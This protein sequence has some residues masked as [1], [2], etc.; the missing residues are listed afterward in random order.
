MLTLL[1][2]ALA[3]EAAPC[4][5]PSTTDTLLV[6]LDAAKALI[7]TN[8]KAASD[9]ATRLVAD[10]TC[11]GEAVPTCARWLRRRR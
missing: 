6:D 8:D 1:S 5:S 10:V 9:A 4:A 2:F 3:A 7:D 11:L